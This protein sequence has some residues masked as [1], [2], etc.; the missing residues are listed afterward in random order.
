[1]HPGP[2]V[3]IVPTRIGAPPR[4]HAAGATARLRIFHDLP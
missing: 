2:A 1:V 4:F 3:A